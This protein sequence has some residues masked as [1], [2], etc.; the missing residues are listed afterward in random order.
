MNVVEKRIACWTI[1]KIGPV[2][3]VTELNYCEHEQQSLWPAKCTELFKIQGDQGV[4]Y[5]TFI[6]DHIWIFAVQN[7]VIICSAQQVCL[8]HHQGTNECQAPRMRRDKHG[9]YGYIPSRKWTLAGKG[10][11]LFLYVHWVPHDLNN[12]YCRLWQLNCALKNS[13][14]IKSERYMPMLQFC[15]ICAMST[16]NLVL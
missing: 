16:S 11:V 15:N 3:P 14:K 4:N 8:Q 10:T 6:D 9:P 2:K 7:V 1:D 13:L 12:K 5:E